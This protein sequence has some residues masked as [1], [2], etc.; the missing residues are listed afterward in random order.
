MPREPPHPHVDEALIGHLWQAS[1]GLLGIV[2]FAAPTL[3]FKTR[4]DSRRRVI[5]HSIAEPTPKDALEAVQRQTR[6]YIML[7]LWPDAC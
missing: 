1:A 6:F 2:L 7:G 4:T 3:A 5:S